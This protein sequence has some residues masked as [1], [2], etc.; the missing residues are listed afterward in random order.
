MLSLYLWKSIIPAVLKAQWSYSTFCN[1]EH[2]VSIGRAI[3]EY[4]NYY[5]LWLL[6]SGI[7]TAAIHGFRMWKPLLLESYPTQA[8]LIPAVQSTHYVNLFFNIHD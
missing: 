5:C 1:E 3:V 6:F 8:V 7:S 4:N 2:N